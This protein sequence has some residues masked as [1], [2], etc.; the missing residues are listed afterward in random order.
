MLARLVR[1]YLTPQFLDLT[2]QIVVVGFK[3]LHSLESGYDKFFI[4]QH[5]RVGD[6]LFC[7][8]RIRVKFGPT[9]LSL[10]L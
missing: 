10:R 1:A 6:L 3:F 4:L 7:A 9:C 8:I 5:K 2:T